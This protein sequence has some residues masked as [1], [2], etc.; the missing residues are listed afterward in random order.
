MLLKDIF[1]KKVDR[2]IEG[3]IKADD[4]ASLLLEV[5][6]YILTQE[7]EKRLESFLDAYKNYE[8][9]NGV[10][11]SGFFGSGKSHLLKILALLLENRTIDDTQILDLFLP[12]CRD[13]EILR[14]DIKAAVAIPSK[15]ILFNI[16]QKAEVISKT[17][18]DALL[19]VFV[20]VF[21][22]MC[23]YYGKQGYIAQFERD[24]DDRDLYEPFKE[25]YQEIAG[26]SWQSGR[27]VTLLEGP[28]IAKAYGQVTDSEDSVATGIIDKY[29]SDYKL[30]IEDFA[31][32]INTYIEQQEPNFRLNFFV[33]EVGQYIAGNTKLMTNLQTVAESLATK[34]R[35]RA[36]VI[37]TAQED[38]NAV[39]GEVGT[40]QAN[41]FSKIQARFANRMK[42]TSADVAEVIQKRLLLKNEH[43]VATLSD[44]YHEQTNNFKTLFG[45]ADGSQ[46]YQN[47]KD[48]DHFI[49]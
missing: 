4:E 9:A 16:D 22:E 34:C 14:G 41:D 33:D 39:V 38:M 46:T 13:N 15:S 35:G 32:Q 27:E 1:E 29:R 43:G 20:K 18:V 23:G 47:F 31:S 24:L 2:S 48:R 12:K 5:E 40:K 3:V 7:V 44:V 6:E 36:W 25:A 10:W 30:S 19:S 17:Q 28:N 49:H 45:F 37:V 26:Q 21:D 11:V 42:L 8:G